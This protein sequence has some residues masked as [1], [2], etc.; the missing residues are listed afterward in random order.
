MLVFP[1]AKINL[2]LNVVEK[3]PDG[4]H[5]I[6]TVLYPVA[7][8]CDA[9]EVVQATKLKFNASGIAIDGNAGD[10]LVVKAYKLLQNDFD[11]PLVHIHL[12]KNIPFGAGLGGGS[13]DAAFMLRLLNEKFSLNLSTSTLENYARKLGA[14]CPFFIQNKPVFAAGTGDIFQNITMKSL[15][16]YF[17]LLVKPEVFVSTANAYKTVQINNISQSAAEIVKLP[18]ERWK[19]LLK[20]DFEQGIFALYP[21]IAA[22]KNKMYETGAIY[23]SMSGSG[24]TVYGIFKELPDNLGQYF[25]DCFVWQENL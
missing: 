21:Q 13:S 14:D 20:N 11:L 22:I 10:N 15:K 8:L 17:L 23:A 3:R 1:N 6:E 4:Y 7:G 9:L 24:S 16:N 19:I 18:M 12:R 5:N 2:G 25:Q